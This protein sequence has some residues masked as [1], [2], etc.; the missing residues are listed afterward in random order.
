MRLAQDTSATRTNVRVH[1]NIIPN[2]IAWIVVTSSPRGTFPS[3]LVNPLSHSQIIHSRT[4]ISKE[5][6]QSVSSSYCG[7]RDR[8]PTTHTPFKHRGWSRWTRLR[9]RRPL[10]ASR[11]AKLAASTAYKSRATVS[12]EQVVTTADSASTK[13]E[14]LTGKRRIMDFL[15]APLCN[16]MRDR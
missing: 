8:L 14:I 7:S 13:A 16:A 11:V 1:A 6:T 15:L 10:P 9:L 3:F 2:A 12:P 5:D 4:K